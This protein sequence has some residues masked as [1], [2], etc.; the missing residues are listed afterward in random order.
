MINPF[1]AQAPA[2]PSKDTMQIAY[3]DYRGSAMLC[4]DKERR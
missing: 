1:R 4:D 2:M 3:A